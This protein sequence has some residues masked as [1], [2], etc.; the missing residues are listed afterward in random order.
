MKKALLVLVMLLFALPAF[1]LTGISFGLRGGLVTDYDQPGLDIPGSS[2]DQMTLGGLQMRFTKLPMVDIIVT[3]D[4]AW[5]KET[6]TSFGQ[7]LELSRRDLLFSA[8]V[9]YPLDFHV[10]AP[11]AGVG[12]ATHSLGY[13]YVEPLG[14][15]L[16][17]YGVDVPDNSTKL[18]Y[19][20]VGGFE[21][22]LP[23]FP[24]SFGAEFRMNWINTPDKTTKYNSFVAGLNFSLP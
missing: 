9:V 19:H 8:S 3:G 13:D 10:V 16:E 18:G 17:T 2:T 1:A 4:Y 12:V 22:K 24:L 20:L 23:A 11:F 21:L 14:W 6:Y 7:S 5:K 15:S